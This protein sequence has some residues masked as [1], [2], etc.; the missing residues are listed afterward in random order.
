MGGPEA[1]FVFKEWVCGGFLLG[2]SVTVMS[3]AHCMLMLAG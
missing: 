3:F 2:R 1:V